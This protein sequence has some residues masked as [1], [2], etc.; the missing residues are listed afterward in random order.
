MRRSI[1]IPVTL[2]LAASLA[3][4]AADKLGL[5]RCHCSSSCWCRRPGLTA[6]RWVLPISHR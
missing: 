2:Y 4:R 5:Q 1:V 3:T 6:F